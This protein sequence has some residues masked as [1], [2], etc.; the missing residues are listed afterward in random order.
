MALDRPLGID[1]NIGLGKTTKDNPFAS[2]EYVGIVVGKK[3]NYT[4]ETTKY[5]ILV[6]D[7]S[8][9]K[10]R[11]NNKWECDDI[12]TTYRLGHK[13]RVIKYEDEGWFT[14]TTRYFIV[15]DYNG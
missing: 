3:V 7:G 5:K 4:N 8:V 11:L 6:N 13:F 9:F 2:R 10:V 15:G 12:Y 14:I 1:I